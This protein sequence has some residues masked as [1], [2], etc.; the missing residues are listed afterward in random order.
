VRLGSYRIII[1][2]AAHESFSDELLL[3]SN[4]SREAQAENQRRTQ[5][6]RDYVLAFFDKYL[7]TNKGTSLDSTSQRYPEVTI[8][9]FGPALK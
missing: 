2:G 3:L 8:E 6:V 7:K 5:I 4:A 9:R 1:K